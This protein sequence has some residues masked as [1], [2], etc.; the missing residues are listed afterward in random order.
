MNL[1]QIPAGNDVPNDIN[2]VIEIPADSPPVKY[3][4]DKALNGIV[5]D[6]LLPVAMR[7]PCNYGFVPQTL[8]EDGDP[9]DV[10]LVT[11]VPLMPGVVIRSR[12]LGMLRMSD[13]KGKDEKIL[14]VPVNDI[15][16]QYSTINDP[17][18]LS[19]SLI[20]AIAH[21]FEHYKDLDAN[22]WSKIEGWASAEEARQI[23]NDSIRRFQG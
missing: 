5:V 3:E 13:E 17:S 18:G 19:P 6:R 9:I 14:A 8:S 7:Y 12:P 23:I 20:N 16:N 4:F 1:S 2:V 15:T 21:F 10:L 22:K 11:P